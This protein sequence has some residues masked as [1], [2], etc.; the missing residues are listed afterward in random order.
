M[1]K[2]FSI[3]VPV[4][5]SRDAR[6][7]H[8]LEQLD[9][10]SD[11]YEILS[12]RG[13]NPARTRNELVSTANGKIFAFTDDDCEVSATWLTAAA[14]FFNEHPD[15]DVLGGPQLNLA[16]EAPLP[17][18][19][20]YALASRFGT[21]R[22]SRRFAVRERLMHAGELDV[23]S[24]NLFVTARAFAKWGPLDERLSPNEETEFV[25]RV[26]NDGGKIAYDP[27]VVVFHKRR[28]SLAGLARQCFGYGVGRAR[29]GRIEGKRLPGLLQCIPLLF[30]GYLALL[31]LMPLL[32][33]WS[34][35]ALGGVGASVVAAPGAL[36]LT[37]GFVVSLLTAWHRRD[38]AALALMLPTLL[39]IHTSYPSGFLVEC[40]RNREP[41]SDPYPLGYRP[42]SERF[43]HASRSAVGTSVTG[44]VARRRQRADAK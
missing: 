3:I 30:L 41:L 43:A 40:F 19:A 5:P 6:V 14:A 25:R 9:A 11:G 4:A 34:P 15:C 37:V 20:G 21:S 29:Q 16:K 38:G 10:P 35:G 27:T 32:M 7:F 1:L 24:A 13:T 22:T 18:V 36:Y 23:T 26:E 42:E 2:A 12:K 33:L 8:S 31:V 44:T 28:S 39:V 17:R